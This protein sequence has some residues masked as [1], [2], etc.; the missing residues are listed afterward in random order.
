MMTFKTMLILFIAVMSVISICM[1]LQEILETR[2]RRKEAVQE[3]R[4]HD[5]VAREERLKREAIEHNR[6]QL[7]LEYLCNKGENKQ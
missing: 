6:Q 7:A 3:M 1:I 5:M 4:K 2:A